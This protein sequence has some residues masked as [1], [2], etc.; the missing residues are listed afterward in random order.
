MLLNMMQDWAGWLLILFSFSIVLM[1]KNVRSDTKTVLAIWF[2]IIMHHVVASHHV[3]F[4][5]AGMFHGDAATLA[6]LPELKRLSDFS[7]GAVNFTHFLGFIYRAFNSSIL[8]G[9]ELSVLTFVLS[10]MVLVKLIDFLDMRRFRVG[11]ILIFGLLPSMIVFRSV[12]LREPW[13]AL[14]FLLSVYLA[15]R[16]RK[17]PGILN[18]LFLL[19]SASCLALLHHG[20]ARY[21]VYLVVISLFWHIFGFKGGVQWSRNVRILFAGLLIV[22]VII[23]S[24]KIG[25]FMTLGEALDEGAGV[26]LALLSYED[27]RTNFSSVLDTSSVHGIITTVPMIFAEYMFAPFPWQVENAK[28]ICALLESI[29]RFWLLFFAISSW[30]RSSGKIRSCYSFLLITVLGMELVWALGTANW[31]TAVRH[32]VPGFSVIVLLGGPGLIQFMR[33]LKSGIIVREKVSGELNEQVRHM[34]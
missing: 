3:Y 10:C 34:S 2:C 32:H 1:W 15:I 30:W 17:Q 13:Q 25:L 14:V 18:V 6:A 20:L 4:S 22:C 33:V 29:L 9:K 19:M 7:N 12:T 11:I 21:A 5:D 24:Q 28:D 27:V 16:M 26:R 31:G 8:F 23:S